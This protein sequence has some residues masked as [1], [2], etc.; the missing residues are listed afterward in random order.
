MIQ[1]YL[2]IKR[3]ITAEI[4]TDENASGVLDQGRTDGVSC[5]SSKVRDV[6]KSWQSISGPMIMT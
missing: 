6:A 3:V 1:S 2:F 5:I 4:K